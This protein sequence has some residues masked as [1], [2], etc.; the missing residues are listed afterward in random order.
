[1]LHYLKN[2][3]HILFIRLVSFKKVII[4]V[5]WLRLGSRISSSVSVKMTFVRSL[6][7]C[8]T[9]I[10]VLQTLQTG[11]SLD[12]RNPCVIRVSPI[13]RRFM[14]DSS[15]RF[16]LGFS[17]LKIMLLIW[18]NLV[19]WLFHCICSF[20]FNIGFFWSFWSRCKGGGLMRLCL[21]QR[22]QF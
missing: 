6:M 18:F 7:M 8:L 17:H 3:Y 5:F 19:V 10:C 16:K 20:F 2:Y 1:M 11:T 4:F 13:L 21:C 14:V 15:F 22:W 9:E 12:I